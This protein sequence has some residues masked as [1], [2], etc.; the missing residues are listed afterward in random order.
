MPISYEVDESCQ[1]E[2]C[3]TK[4]EICKK[5]EKCKKCN[6]CKKIESIK[7]IKRRTR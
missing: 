5:H 4:Y 2:T 7:N 1:C 3:R 6:C